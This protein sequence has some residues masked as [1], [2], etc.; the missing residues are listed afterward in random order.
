M[1]NNRF[2]GI[3]PHVLP[4]ML[5]LLVA[6]ALRLALWDKLPRQGMIGDEAEYLAAADWLANGRGFAWYQGWL[7]T[8]APALP[9]L[10]WR[11]T[12]GCLALCSP[13]FTSPRC[14]SVCSMWR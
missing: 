9:A 14:C 6:L 2:A 12:C 5:V 8:R 4:L 1:H 10:F 13:R 7:W 11:P 3:Q